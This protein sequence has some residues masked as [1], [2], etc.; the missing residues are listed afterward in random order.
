MIII[1]I[2][3]YILFVLPSVITIAFFVASLIWGFLSYVLSLFGNEKLD[4]FFEKFY[5]AFFIVFL[6]IGFFFSFKF[7][8]FIKPNNTNTNSKQSASSS[9]SS[10]KSSSN[11]DWAADLDE[12]PDTTEITGPL[13]KKTYWTSGGKSY[14]FSSNCTSLKRS[15]DI[16]S[17]TLKEAI[18]EGKRD[19]CNLCADG[20]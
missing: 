3:L 14:H 16:W 8:N 10:K 5:I 18:A 6:I 7:L 13:S 15:S 17:G 9:T 4:R 12:V 1:K 20:S 11:N 19:P 2:L